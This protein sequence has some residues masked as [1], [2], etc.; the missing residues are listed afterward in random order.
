[1]ARPYLWIAV[2]GAFV[3]FLTG[4]G[5]GM[6][7]LSNAFGTTYGAKVLTLS[8]IVI[9]ASVCEFVGAV[10]LGGAV[11]STI[12]GGTPSPPTSKTTLTSSCTV[13]YAPVVPLSAGLRWQPGCRFRCPPRT[14]S[15]EVSLALLWFTAVL[16]Q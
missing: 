3:S 12:S 16:A 6:N 4:A 2:I 13:C 9:L 11:T 5:V 14:A 15:L 1:M 10:S 8:Q 7:D